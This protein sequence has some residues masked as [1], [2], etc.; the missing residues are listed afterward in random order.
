M[1]GNRRQLPPPLD[2]SP[3]RG[4]PGLLWKL[5]VHGNLDLIYQSKGVGTNS[6]NLDM[7]RDGA[8]SNQ[9]RS[10]CD[11]AG[12]DG[13]RCGT[14]GV[15][16]APASVLR[17]CSSGI[18]LEII[19]AVHQSTDRPPMLAST[20]PR[21]MAS[22]GRTR[23][24]PGPREADS[25]CL[26]SPCN[27]GLACCVSVVLETPAHSFPSA[28]AEAF[29]C[30]TKRPGCYFYL[31][32]CD[33]ARSRRR[34]GVSQAEGHAKRGGRGHGTRKVETRGRVWNPS[35]QARVHTAATP[36]MSRRRFVSPWPEG[37]EG[38]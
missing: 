28:P 19:C 33:Q 26:P 32:E 36:R 23:R 21:T 18:G 9:Y 6:C 4:F 22:K 35:P 38:L 16:A 2:P 8:S 12:V 27:L 1:L 10:S 15:G 31:D 17:H 37:V 7:S 5:P 11:S 20:H 24:R 25:T 34:F 3:R 30:F 14:R 29:R 13:W